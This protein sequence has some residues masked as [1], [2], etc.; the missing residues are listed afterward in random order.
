MDG[1]ISS[2]LIDMVSRTFERLELLRKLTNNLSVE[3]RSAEELTWE[4]LRQITEFPLPYQE[5]TKL[6]EY[7]NALTDLGSGILSGEK[8]IRIISDELIKDFIDI[9][10]EEREF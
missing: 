10:K 9:A 1:R 6:S 7:Y 8:E 2:G 3:L 4:I 5:S